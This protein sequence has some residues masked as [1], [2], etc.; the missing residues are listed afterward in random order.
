MNAIKI[1]LISM[2]IFIFNAN[3]NETVNY[4][5]PQ[6]PDELHSLFA[7]YFQAKNLEGLKT[8]FA[9]N[10]KYILDVEGNTAIG[11]DEIA[12]ALK[13]YLSFD[14]EMLTL[15]KSIHINGNIA[16]IR[17][18]W[19]VANSEINGTALEVMQYQNG[20]WVYIIDNPN[21]Y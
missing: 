2:S 21:G 1:L 9:K 7:Q 14:S 19:K 18:D 6:S 4:S 10:A 20:G 12:K 3:A 11:Q 16:L 17:S 15:S 5:K 8:L 13:P